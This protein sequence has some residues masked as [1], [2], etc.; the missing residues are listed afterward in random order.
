MCRIGLFSAIDLDRYVSESCRRR[1][2]LLCPV[3]TQTAI[4]LKCAV[5]DLMVIDKNRVNGVSKYFPA[6]DFKS[7]M[8]PVHENKLQVTE[9]TQAIAV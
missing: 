8:F 4:Y 7:K 5:W 2:G 3:L 1:K 9:R 6:E